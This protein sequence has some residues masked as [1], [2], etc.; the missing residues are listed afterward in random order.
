MGFSR[1]PLAI[2]TN[3]DGRW[4]MPTNIARLIDENA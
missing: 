4:L 2:G 3:A 1:Q